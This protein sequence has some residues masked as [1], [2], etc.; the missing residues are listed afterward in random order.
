MMGK[1]DH[2]LF[3]K[4]QNFSPKKSPVCIFCKGGYKKEQ[5]DTYSTLAIVSFSQIDFVSTVADPD[6]GSGV[7]VEN[8]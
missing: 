1:R 2:D 5:C 4:Q 3:S 7:L 6:I 8:T